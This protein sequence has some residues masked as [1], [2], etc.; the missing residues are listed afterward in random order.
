ME[1]IILPEKGIGETYPVT[2]TFAD[3]LQSGEAINGAAVTVTV[4]AGTD[5][6]PSNLLSGSATYTANTVTQVITGGVAG[7]IYSLVYVATGTSSHNYAKVARL[8]VVANDN[9]FA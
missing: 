9:P 7:V 3:K 1:T 8:A 4:Y 5:A 2:I 6:T